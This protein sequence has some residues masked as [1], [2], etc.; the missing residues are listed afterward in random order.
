MHILLISM[1]SEYGDEDAVDAATVLQTLF[2]VIPT[3]ALVSA[4]FRLIRIQNKE[5]VCR[6]KDF[7]A[8]FPDNHPE[9]EVRDQYC[10]QLPLCCGKYRSIHLI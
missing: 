5:T 6:F 10:T 9:K 1:K 3:Y 8:M 2:N 4:I 7:S